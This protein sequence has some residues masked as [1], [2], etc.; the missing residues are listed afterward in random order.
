[1]HPVCYFEIG[2]QNLPATTEFYKNVFGWNIDDQN[3]VGPAGPGT[4][5]GHF[6]SLGHEPHNYVT[7]Y[8]QV[9]DVAAALTKAAQGGGSILIPATQIP[10]DR[11]TFGWFKDPAGNTL[12]VYSNP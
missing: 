5:G 7:I 9:E 3:H 12:G 8:L 6:N 4:I 10:G 2:C 1:M 11:G